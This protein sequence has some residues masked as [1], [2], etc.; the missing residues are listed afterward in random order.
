MAKARSV[1][2]KLNRLR[3][4]RDEAITPDIL[5]EL[6]DALADKSNFVAAAAAEIAGERALADLVPNL[7]AAFQRFLID[8]V[9]TDKLCRAKIAIIDALHKL[10]YDSEEFFRAALR[11]TQ[12]E[13]GWGKSDDTAGPVRATAAFALVRIGPRD[14]M[15]LL[16]DLLTDP[17]KIVRS[18]AAKALGATGQSAA[19]PLLRFKARVGD[20]EAEVVGECLNALIAI[21][22]AGSIPFVGN[23]LSSSEEEVAEGAALAL[24]ESRRP[25]A[26]ELLKKHWPKSRGESLRSVLL[27]AMAITRLP[28]AIDFLIEILAGRDASAWKPALTAL[29]IHRHNPSVRDR[30]S[31]IVES[32][33][34]DDLKARF[35]KEFGKVGV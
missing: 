20:E 8:G 29:A 28:A 17:E 3:L 27:V 31:A 22:V 15:L 11:I 33:K 23:F 19:V 5:T 25:E 14:V 35:A 18:A 24:A 13:P 6:R 2:A 30:V 34:N 26:F 7:A 21:D 1:E 4:V 16:T 9:E 32:K 12:I 10:D